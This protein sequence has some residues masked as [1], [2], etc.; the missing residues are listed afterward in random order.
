MRVNGSSITAPV[1]EPIPW[2]GYKS[3]SA[4]WQDQSEFQP[5]QAA[6]TYDYEEDIIKESASMGAA[7]GF[8]IGSAL[9]IIGIPLSICFGMSRLKI[10]KCNGREKARKAKK[11]LPVLIVACWPGTIVGGLGAGVGG[12]IGAAKGARRLA[13]LRSHRQPP[14][15]PKIEASKDSTSS[16]A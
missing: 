11:L 13:M 3:P 16:Q 10:V 7:L 8:K 12:A 4:F 9:T 1:L 15:A 14:L 5:A 2:A 6:T